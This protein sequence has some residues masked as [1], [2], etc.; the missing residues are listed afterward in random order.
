VH[1]KIINGKIRGREMQSVLSGA[2]RVEGGVV[3]CSENLL[4]D[5]Q[6]KVDHSIFVMFATRQCKA[7]LCITTAE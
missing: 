7:L 2:I 3:G 6:C 4:L 5:A 1:F